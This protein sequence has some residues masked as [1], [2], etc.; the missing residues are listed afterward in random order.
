MRTSPPSGLP[1]CPR[2]LA[3]PPLCISVP[4][5]PFT[6]LAPRVS[7]DSDSPTTLVLQPGPID[8]T[9]PA[10]K[11]SLPGHLTPTIF[12]EHWWLETVTGG[13]YQAVEYCQG[14]RL[15]GWLPYLLSRRRGFAVSVM[16]DITYALGPAIDEGAG[17]SNKRWLR[18]LDILQELATKLPR[19][20]F[21][22]Q[23]CHPDTPDVLG[24]QACGF[25]TA[26]QF[27]AEVSPAPKEVMWMAMRDKTRNVIR[28][29]A[30]RWEV[31]ETDDPQ[32]FKRY[33]RDN[34]A[35]NHDA[36]YFDLETIASVFAAAHPRQ[37]CAIFM[38]RNAEQHIAAA[39]FYVWDERRMWYLLSSR[40]PTLGENGAVSL[41]IW[42]AMQDA[43]QRGLVFDFHGVGAAGTA[44]FYAGF[45][46][47]LK[48]RFAVHR[49]SP[50]FQFF[51]S[52]VTSLRGR[53]TRNHFTAP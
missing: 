46:A 10:E 21:F 5:T 48:P 47:T 44:R 33:Y 28:R 45:G 36:S 22:S 2:N 50:G 7:L 13:R 38:A 42:H 12:H 17:G 49:S 37:R 34:L 15:V 40:D 39:V 9:P 16:P 31:V 3:P 4:S 23:T 29:A 26:V 35:R 25:D 24:F 14:G 1:L 51:G 6:G 20:G 53:T 19:V 43:A 8:S 32:L 30:E 52:V 18:R 27:S 11:K 41:L